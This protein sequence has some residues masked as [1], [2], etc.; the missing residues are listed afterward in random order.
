M[1]G[2]LIGLILIM[3]IIL[4][5]ISTSLDVIATPPEPEKILLDHD[6]THDNRD[7]QLE[8]TMDTIYVYDNQRLV[9]K[10]V[11]DYSTK[12]DSILLKDNE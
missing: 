1:M 2:I 9:S 3:V 11:T 10:Y 8:L 6:C 12:L 4:L 5:N 7:Y